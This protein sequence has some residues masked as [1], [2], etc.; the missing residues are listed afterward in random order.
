MSSV[1]SLSSFSR[2]LAFPASSLLPPHPCYTDPFAVDPSR[3]R[4]L[5]VPTVC[6]FPLHT[7]L[8]ISL[9]SE[10][11]CGERFSTLTIAM[12]TD[13]LHHH[14]IQT[15]PASGSTV[16]VRTPQCRGIFGAPIIGYCK[17]LIAPGTSSDTVDSFLFSSTLYVWGFFVLMSWWLFIK[18]VLVHEHHLKGIFCLTHCL[19]SMVSAS[20]M[21]T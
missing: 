21:F 9:H 8:H 10:Q 13:F 15:T 6:R 20:V 12:I 17:L 7:H 16:Q 14:A 18:L 2:L 5:P 3:E 4:N 11:P 19:P 1:W